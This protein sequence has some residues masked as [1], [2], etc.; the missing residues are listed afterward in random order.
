MDLNNNDKSYI[1][2]EIFGESYKLVGK[3]HQKEEILNIVHLINE[4]MKNLS[5]AFPQY[6][7]K[8]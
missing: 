2:V 6:S 7:K 4:K 8:K 5:M 1:D 3:D